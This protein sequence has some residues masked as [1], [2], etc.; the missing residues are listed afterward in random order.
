M[1]GFE[2]E[3][4]RHQLE[5]ATEV[6]LHAAQT[7][8][9]WL[10][11]GRINDVAALA[12]RMASRPGTLSL[13]V[14][15]SERRL[16][17]SGGESASHLPRQLAV[18]A[19]STGRVES[20]RAGDGRLVVAAPIRTDTAH[21]MASHGA[22]AVEISRDGFRYD[23]VQALA[24]FFVF[25]AAL[26]LAA[27]PVTVLLVRRAL[28]PLEALTSFA[29][30]V[31]E[32]RD[33]APL[34]LR[35]GDEFETLANAFNHMI[36]R[37][38]A[39]MHKA[40]AVAFVDP[41]TQL[42]NQER[43]HREVDFYILQ[44]LKRR[45]IGAVLVVELR[46]LTGFSQTLDRGTASDLIRRA[47]ERVAAAAQL[48]NQRMKRSGEQ[49]RT[50]LAARLGASDFAVLATNV[51]AP[52]DA[53]RF[54]QQ[55]N[56]ALNQPFEWRGHKLSLLAAC[57]VALAPRDGASSDAVVRRAR[58]ALNAARGMPAQ[59][60][61]FTQS[62]DRE[63]VARLSLERDMRDGLERNEFRAYFQPKINLANGKIEGAEAL[64]R[65]V[66][67]DRTIVSPARFIPVAEESGL[68]AP[69]SEAIM[70]EACWKAAAW[71]RAGAPAK[72]AVNVSSLQFRDERFAERVLQI[73]QHAGLAPDHL[74]LEITESIA[75]E[76]PE[77]A[78]RAIEPLRQAGVKLA[79]DDFGCGHSS[80]AALSKLPFDIIKIDQQF[81]RDLLLGETHAAAIV[82]MILALARTLGLEI[83]AEGVERPEQAE[84]VASRGCQWGQGF[85]YGAA[86]PAAEFIALLVRQ[87]GQ[88]DGAS[89]AP[90]GGENSGDAAAA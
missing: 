66:R 70:R 83:V 62:L 53:V 41:T 51:G 37:L 31:S 81:I 87:K 63:A 34:K 45:E 28:A 25:L 26:F 16:A 71:A 50:V 10:S 47:G 42:P 11:Q 19:L 21:G 73:V 29:E 84:F 55:L 56:A 77:R 68:I 8:G 90:R 43:F 14:F 69:L 1:F 40:H 13:S 36:A 4:Q 32:T 23:A 2:R 82:E 88:L 54:A 18:R 74:E 65:W 59:L 17:A 58:M 57:G 27:L 12:A 33:A 39:S 75:I 35:S 61:V 48:V 49:Q 22:V 72:V 79:I 3:S 80:L 7:S 15:D 44:A 76:D 24:P 52:E 78:L 60:K 38:K 46:R 67:P 30:K 64:A 9:P 89:E 86:M 85:Y 20:A 6:V 5:S